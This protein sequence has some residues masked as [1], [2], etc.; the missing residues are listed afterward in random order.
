M[1][2]RAKIKT[3]RKTVAIFHSLPPFIAILFYSR[4]L[5]FPTSMPLV[6]FI[7]RDYYTEF[8]WLKSIDSFLRDYSLLLC[9][10]ALSLMRTAWYT[11]TIWRKCFCF[12]VT[13]MFF[14]FSNS[15]LREREKWKKTFIITPICVQLWEDYSKKNQINMICNNKVIKTYVNQKSHCQQ[16][17]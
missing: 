2:E 16:V 11:F 14:L 10:F 15:R 1:K 6:F 13:Y 3:W 9:A 17:Q 4:R 8:H 5:A 7:S 12:F